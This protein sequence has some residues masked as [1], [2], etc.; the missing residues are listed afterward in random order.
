MAAQRTLARRNA[1]VMP[2]RCRHAGPMHD[3]R[4]ARGG[5]RAESRAALESWEDDWADTG[6]EEGGASAGAGCPGEEPP[7][8]GEHAPLIRVL[9]RV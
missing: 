8:S 6:R 7:R 5:P 3:R 4:A 1:M 2:A 9:R